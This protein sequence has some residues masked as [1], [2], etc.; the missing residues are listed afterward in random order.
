MSGAPEAWYPVFWNLRGRPV[1]VIGGGPLA[2]EKVRGLRAAGAAITVAAEALCGELR[3]AVKEGAV[4]WTGRAHERGGM[5]GCAIVMAATG[6]AAENAALFAEARE[7]GVPIN[8]ADDPA[9]CDFILPSVVRDPP[10]TLA[11]S[12]GG[13]SP[14]MSRRLREELS[15]FLAEDAGGLTALVGETRGELRRLG[16]FAPI[17][18]DAWQDAIDGKLRALVAQRRRGQAKALLLA[19]LGAGLRGEAAAHPSLLAPCGVQRGDA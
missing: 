12:T 19:R 15:D 18:A 9:H 11:I 1:L 17:P 13:A 3:A 10:V 6:D 8:A 4:C 14:A 16:A 5:A 2:A 7:C